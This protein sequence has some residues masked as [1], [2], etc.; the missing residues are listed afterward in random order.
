LVRPFI[1]EDVDG[2]TA[3]MDRFWPMRRESHSKAIK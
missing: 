2:A 3:E 1:D